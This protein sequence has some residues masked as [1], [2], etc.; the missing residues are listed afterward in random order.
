MKS[1]LET[2]LQNLIIGACNVQDV[3]VDD[4]GATDPLF[5]PDSPMGLDSLD[6]IEIIVAVQNA[7]GVH[8]D[9][10]KLAR[11]LLQSLR[12]LADFIHSEAP[13]G[14]SIRAAAS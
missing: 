8:I 10:Q 3:S 6:A 7:Y 1:E 2:E 5:G 13:G 4:I 11:K 12:T 14:K 9:S